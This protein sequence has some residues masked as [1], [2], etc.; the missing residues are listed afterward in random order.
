[1]EKRLN[2]VTTGIIRVLH[3][4]VIVFHRCVLCTTS[5]CESRTSLRY[6]EMLILI[7]D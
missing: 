3:I 4:P 2:Y 7:V 1:M 6:A 5:V